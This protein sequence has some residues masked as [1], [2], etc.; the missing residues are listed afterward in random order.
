MTM[1]IIGNIHIGMKGN[2]PH[3]PGCHIIVSHLVF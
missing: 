2:H 3:A 1:K